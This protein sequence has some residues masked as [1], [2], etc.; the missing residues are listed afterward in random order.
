MKSGSPRSFNIIPILLVACTIVIASSWYAVASADKKPNTLT[1]AV[2]LSSEE[3]ANGRVALLE[4]D[5]NELGLAATDLK[6]KFRDQSIALIQHPIKPPGIYIGL[7]GIPL[8][9]APENAII[10]LEWTDSRGHQTTSIPLRILDGKYKSEAFKVD[11][12]HVTLSKKNLQR[13]KHEKK[14][15]RRIYSSSSDTRRWFGNFKRPLASDTTSSF[16]TRRLFN[17]QH[18]SYHRGTDFRANVGTPV[19]ASNSGIVR[20]AKNLFYSGN[21]VIVDHGMSIFTNYAHLSKIQVVAGQVIARGHQI[22]LS[23]A[24][25]RVSGPHLHWAVK[26]NGAY[27]DPLQ[28]LTVI[29]TLLGR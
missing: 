26:V 27:V 6:A 4:I 7:I 9:A 16:G 12:R 18:R 3:V 15:I 10:K 22:G 23:G 24:S 11:P 25:G 1:A 17:G 28:F 13:V 20:L 14:E 21:I 8:S 29:S 19:Y 5:F 2:N